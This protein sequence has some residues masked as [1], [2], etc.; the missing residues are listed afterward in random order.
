MSL[1]PKLLKI[2][3]IGLILL[4]FIFF[5]SI[6]LSIN[7]VLGQNHNFSKKTSFW[8]DQQNLYIEIYNPKYYR[9]FYPNKNQINIFLPFEFLYTNDFQ[10]SFYSVKIDNY[11]PYYSVIKI[12]TPY[13]LPYELIAKNEEENKI[14]FGFPLEY[15]IKS[16]VYFYKD[17]LYNQKKIIS[18]LNYYIQVLNMNENPVN[19]YSYCIEVPDISLFKI[20]FITNDNKEELL[21]KSDNFWFGLNGTYFARNN[22]GKYFTVAGV[23]VDNNVLSY[24]V[25]YRPYRGFWALLRKEDSYYFLFDRLPNLRKDFLRYIEVLRS[26]YDIKFLLQAGPLIYKDSVFVMDP[27]LEAFGVKG[28]N[29]IDPA[30]RTVVHMDKDGNLKLEVIYGQ[31]LKR[32]EGLSL[33]D[34]AYYLQDSQNALNLDGGSSSVIYINNKKLVPIFQKSINYKSQ[35]YIVFRTDLNYNFYSDNQFYYYF[36]GIFSLNEFVDYT[37]GNKF[38]TFFDG[39]QKFEKLIYNDNLE[40][41]FSDNGDKIFIQTNDIDL[42]LERLKLNSKVKKIIKYYNCYVLELD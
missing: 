12:N 13:P 11:F 1:I 18:K 5:L 19:I 24:P 26:I 42:A 6:F 9:I 2:V 27:D 38:V 35:N 16:T 36:P 17:E 14:I 40:Y 4:F 39:Y 15:K 7:L 41:F 25:E 32:K 28:N 30:P 34:L 33:Y 23:V 10:Y 31:N 37:F 20:D 22:N 3:K 21:F 29:I 8:Y